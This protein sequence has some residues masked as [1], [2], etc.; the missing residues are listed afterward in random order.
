MDFSVMKG[1]IGSYR[2]RTITREMF[3]RLWTEWQEQQK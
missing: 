3:V 2:R 1:I